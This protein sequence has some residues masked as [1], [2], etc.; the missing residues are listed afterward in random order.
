MKTYSIEIKESLVKVIKV[1]AD[2]IKDALNIV[3]KRYQESEIVLDEGHFKD[4]SIDIIE[5]KSM[6]NNLDFTNFVLS[7][8][9]DMIANLSIEELAK[10]GFGDYFEAIRQF[11]SED[12]GN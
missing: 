8:A 5:E 10:I 4:L 7:K 2:S 9:E 6:E 12:Y 3:T 1:K 11:N